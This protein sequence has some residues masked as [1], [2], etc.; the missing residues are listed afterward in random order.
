M[1]LCAIALVIIVNKALDWLKI[2]V[3]GHPRV[4]ACLCGFG[5]KPFLP[6]IESLEISTIGGEFPSRGNQTR[7]FLCTLLGGQGDSRQL[8]RGRNLQA[9]CTLPAGTGT[10]RRYR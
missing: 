3:E 9:G 2:D 10:A 6:V 8:D 1:P 7:A 4:V 5:V